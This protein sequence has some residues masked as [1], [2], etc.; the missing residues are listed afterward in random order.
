MVNTKGA[1][2]VRS[3]SNDLTGN[4]SATVAR[5][6]E[7]PQ[8]VAARADRIVELVRSVQGNV[9][10]FSS[11]HFL[12]MLAARWTGMDMIAAMS[13]TLSN[14]SLSVLGYENGLAQPAIR[15]WND[16]HHLQP[17]RRST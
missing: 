16:T 3:I 17:H 4:Y 9:L 1:A 13:L 7:S 6:G 15:L 14:A 11:G 10:L 8:Q 5:G 2:Q 12:R